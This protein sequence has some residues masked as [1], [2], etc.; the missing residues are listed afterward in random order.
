[1]EPGPAH[2]LAEDTF[3]GGVDGLF[4]GVDDALQLGVREI[5][6]Q[7]ESCD[8]V[9]QPIPLTHGIIVRRRASG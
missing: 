6:K 2:A 9:D 4:E 8:R 1:M 3:P 7:A 5:R